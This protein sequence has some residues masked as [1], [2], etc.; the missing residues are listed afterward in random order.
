M[1]QILIQMP[2]FAAVEVQM[3]DDTMWRPVVLLADRKSNPFIEAT[4]QNF[5]NL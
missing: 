4:E 2:N 1:P 5:Q 3:P